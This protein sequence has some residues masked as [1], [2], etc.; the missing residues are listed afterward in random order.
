MLGD[1]V[2]AMFLAGCFVRTRPR[3]AP[4]RRPSGRR[5]GRASR[6]R[7]RRKPREP[8]PWSSVVHYG[9]KLDFQSVDSPESFAMR[10]RCGEDC[11][12][13]K[14]V[15]KSKLGLWFVAFARP[16][17]S[18]DR[19][20]CGQSASR[21]YLLTPHRAAGSRAGHVARKTRNRCAAPPIAAAP[22]AQMSTENTLVDHLLS[23]V[24]VKYRICDF[25]GGYAAADLLARLS[26]EA[27]PLTETYLRQV[28][29]RGEFLRW[30]SK[31]EY[32]QTEVVRYANDAVCEARLVVRRVEQLE[33]EEQ[34]KFDAAYSDL[35]VIE[36]RL[37]NAATEKDDANGTSASGTPTASTSASASVSPSRD[38]LPRPRRTGAA[39]GTTAERE[40]L[41]EEAAHLLALLL[42]WRE[43]SNA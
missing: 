40:R 33:A 7:R 24:D 37:A 29:H 38:A 28:S 22:R 31:S 43:S 5:S 42:S 9:V 10:R 41:R 8:R 30:Q 27:R 21:H 18:K 17:C 36:E 14:P 13:V 6:K 26:K 15:S 32:A 11:D 19:Y 4:G 3:L 2:A 1:G 12:R 25:A 20:C 16:A 39:L 35:D 34:E 23:H